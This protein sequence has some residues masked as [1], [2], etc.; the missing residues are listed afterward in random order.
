MG[1]RK[2]SIP[3]GKPFFLSGEAENGFHENLNAEA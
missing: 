3:E 2:V 1:Y